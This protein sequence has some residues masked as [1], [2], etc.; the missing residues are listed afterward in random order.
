MGIFRD[1]L[2][3]IFGRKKQSD[4]FERGG[5]IA[6]KQEEVFKNGGL[7]AEPEMEVVHKV[8][9]DRACAENELSEPNPQVCNDVQK[10]VNV[11]PD[12]LQRTKNV[13]GLKKLSQIKEY[14]LTYGS[15]DTLTCEEKFKVKSLRN[16]IWYLRKDG[17]KIKTQKV[18]L[19]DE[20]GQKVEVVNYVLIGEIENG[21]D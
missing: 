3:T 11:Y 5:S 2:N 8:S 19:Q 9:E 16:F 10:N 1:I 21:A 14:L 18:L 4:R 17:L 6:E 7:I 12:H 15:I 13:I 20:L